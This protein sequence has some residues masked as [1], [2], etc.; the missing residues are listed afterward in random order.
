ML[1]ILRL[2]FSTFSD[3]F[4]LEEK[5]LNKINRFLPARKSFPLAGMK[6][7]VE[8]YFSATWKKK[9]TGWNLLKMV[10][11]WF[12][13]VRKSVAGII[14]PEQKLFLKKWISP[15]FNNASHKQ[16]ESSRIRTQP[17]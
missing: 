14:F 13:P 6:D 12:A 17:E 11:E 5:P 4:L 10:K 9:I 15:N 3:G 8:K 2:S 7:F 16:K 1:F